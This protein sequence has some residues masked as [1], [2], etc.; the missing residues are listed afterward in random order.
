MMQEKQTIQ[1]KMEMTESILEK[2][3]ED[4]QN[5]SENFSM[6]EAESSSK[7]QRLGEVEQELSATSHALDKSKSEAEQLQTTVMVRDDEMKRIADTLEEERRKRTELEISC[8][9]LEETLNQVKMDLTA[10]LS[11]TQQDGETKSRELVQLQSLKETLQAQLADANAKLE[12]MGRAL[13]EK[14]SLI[15][16]IQMKLEHGEQVSQEE[17]VKLADEQASYWKSE[18]RKKEGEVD[19][20]KVSCGACVHFE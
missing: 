3:R 16:Q 4:F 15:Q 20:S 11:D 13:A 7:Q 12:N 9:R 19:K 10:K 14:D 8:T 6:L 1:E 18:I 5:L 17:M 2:L